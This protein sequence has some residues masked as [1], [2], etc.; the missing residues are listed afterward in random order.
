MGFTLKTKHNWTERMFFSLSHNSRAAGHLL[1]GRFRTGKR[2]WYFSQHTIHLWN[3]LPKDVVMA[4]SEQRCH[5]KGEWII[6]WRWG[7]SMAID[8]D[9]CMK[10]PCP[11]VVGLSLDTRWW[12][13]P[14][15]EELLPAC[16][17]SGWPVCDVGC[18]T[19]RE[20]TEKQNVK[21]CLENSWDCR[22]GVGW[23]G[24]DNTFVSE[25]LF[26]DVVISQVYNQR[27]G[28]GKFPCV[29]G[30]FAPRFASGSQH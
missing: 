28:R 17:A 29:Q 18:W 24:E 7:L 19:I 4:I 23:S 5:L 27:R 21:G 6:S 26:W 30:N 11:R 3:T 1:S 22:V 15:P 8:H 10:P 16:V 14:L 12:G 13:A 20:Q 2:K 9:G 25:E